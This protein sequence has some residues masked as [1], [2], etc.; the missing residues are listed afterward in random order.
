[1]SLKACLY[2]EK[3]TVAETADTIETHGK[4]QDNKSSA[5]RYDFNMK[6]HGEK[7]FITENLHRT[8][9]VLPKFNT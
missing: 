1:L 9:L 2:H 5:K 6:S 3:K 8:S 7:A 4:R